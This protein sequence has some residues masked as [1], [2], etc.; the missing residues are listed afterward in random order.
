M[1]IRDSVIVVGLTS[2]QL[3]N[4]KTALRYINRQATDQRVDDAIESSGRYLNYDLQMLQDYVGKYSIQK[5]V[6]YFHDTEGFQEAM[7]SD[8][9]DVFRW[10]I[11]ISLWRLLIG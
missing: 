3:P 4:L 2:T 6:L 7:L 8:L 11:C 5:I 9:I 1:C 10:V